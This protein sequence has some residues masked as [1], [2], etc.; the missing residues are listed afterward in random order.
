MLSVI[1]T[2]GKVNYYMGFELVD[3]EKHKMEKPTEKT[4]KSFINTF[5]QTSYAEIA[6]ELYRVYYY[7]SH[8]E[9]IAYL[10]AVYEINEKINIK[11]DKIIIKDSEDPCIET[12]YFFVESPDFRDPLHITSLKVIGNSKEVVKNHLKTKGQKS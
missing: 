3:I 7:F 11:N 2:I 1:L 6:E 12:E 8:R 10:P 4:N 9:N 5:S